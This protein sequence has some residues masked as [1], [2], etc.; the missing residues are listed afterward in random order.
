MKSLAQ[1]SS[2]LEL[3]FANTG[4]SVR[5]ETSAQ[6]HL[7]ALCFQMLYGVTEIG[8]PGS[9]QEFGVQ[10]DFRDGVGKVT[11]RLGPDTVA[12]GHIVWNEGFS[13]EAWTQVKSIY[14]G[15]HRVA[16]SWFAPLECPRQT[17]WLI[18]MVFPGSPTIS[19]ATWLELA[20]ITHG[21]GFA[22]MRLAKCE[23]N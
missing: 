8:I 15:V 14:D 11:L 16:P 2:H 17:P 13:D 7:D 12:M 21:F 1:N 18:F 4:E 10:P 22:M 5:R 23:M 9:A 20:K 19:E 3:F 6:T